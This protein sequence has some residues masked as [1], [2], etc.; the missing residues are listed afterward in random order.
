MKLSEFIRSDLDSILDAWERFA[1]ELPSATRMTPA[2]LRD[3]ARGMLQAIAADLDCAQSPHQQT[4]KSQGRGPLAN[5]RTDAELHG[6]DRVSAGFSVNEGLS[7]FRALRASV[8]KLWS[9]STPASP[10]RID[11]DLVRFNEAIDQALAESVERY[12]S[13]KEKTTRLFDTLL[14]SL[15]DLNFIVDPKGNFIYA[16]KAM[17]EQYDIALGNVAGRNIADIDVPIAGITSKL[18][19]VVDSRQAKRAETAHKGPGGEELTYEYLLAPLLDHKGNVAAVAALVRDITEGKAYEENIRRAANFD[20]LTS[21]PNRSVFRDRLEQEAKRSER[22]QLP[23]ALLFIDLDGFKGVN[24]RFGHDAGDA[25]LQ[26]VAVRT[27]ACVRSTDTVARMGGDEFTVIL[28]AISDLQHVDIVAQKLLD[29]LARPFTV[30]GRDIAISGSIGITVFPLDATS[31]A[32]LIGNAD[33]AMYA[34]KHAGRNRYSFYS[35]DLRAAAWTRLKLLDELR[36]ALAAGELCVHYQPIV[37]LSLGTIIKAEA[38][39]RWQHP[40]VGLML[41]ESFLGL[42]EEAGLIIAIDEWVLGEAKARAREWSAML[43]TSFQIS[44]NQSAMEFLGKRPMKTWD[45]QLAGVTALGNPIAIELSEGILEHASPMVVDKLQALHDAGIQLSIDRLGTGCSTMVRL[46]QIGVD[47]LK[48]DKS[49]VHDALANP[50]LRTVG[51]ATIVMAHMLGLKVIAEGV[52]S[53]GQCDWL[54]TAGCD[55]A[56]GNYFSG[57]LPSAALDQLLAQRKPPPRRSGPDA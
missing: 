51:E 52:E 44:V 19:Q 8:M 42:A 18:C 13:D 15:P 45:S 35:A 29:E 26:Q 41:P 40:G 10:P 11:E 54:K 4:E 6:A 3:H 2:A 27:S 32:D 43:G 47:Y 55:Y 17:A 46:K 31:P 22:S 48:I 38:L 5:Q 53:P 34:A 21:L 12:S 23:M 20:A 1:R 9:Q 14:S 37:D 24:D 16:N 28:A 33:Q 50:D 25:L 57:P 56:Q 39:L 7:E 36:H 30:C 49:L